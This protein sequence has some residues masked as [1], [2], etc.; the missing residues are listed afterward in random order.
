[1]AIKRVLLNGQVVTMN[2]EASEATAFA[3]MG[4]RFSAVGLDD[5]IRQWADNQTEK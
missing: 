3:I 1:M 5:E 4:D 2:T